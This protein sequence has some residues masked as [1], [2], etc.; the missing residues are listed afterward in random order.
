MQVID[1]E[2]S[3]GVVGL[4]IALFQILAQCAVIV[5]GSHWSGIVIP[6]LLLVIAVIQRVYLRTS[7]Q[8]RLLDLE[9]KAPL[10]THFLETLDGLITLRAFGWTAEYIERGID[11]MKRSQQPFYL[12]YS[13]QNTLGLT[14][15]LVTAALAVVV[16]SIAVGTRSSTS[17][18]LG[19]ALFNI[20]GLGQTCKSVVTTWTFL[21]TSLGAVARI[22]DFEKSTPSEISEDDA[23]PPDG[24]PGSGNIEFN[25]VQVAYSYVLMKPAT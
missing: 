16:M 11:A 14:L 6:V 25:H 4:S 12:L 15:D 9:A 22:R 10:F 13:A 23:Q 2:I 21:E 17:G 1:R 3:F 20:V 24:W 18:G 19:L 7:Q 5:V 8:L